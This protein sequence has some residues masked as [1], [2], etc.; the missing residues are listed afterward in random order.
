M[1]PANAE[2]VDAYIESL[3]TAGDAVLDGALAMAHGAGLPE[4]QVSAAQGKL[5]YLLARAMGAS[6][7]LEIGTL[8]GYSGIWL[9][10]ALP[11]TGTLVTLEKDS[12]H[13]AV[14]RAN[15]EGAGL[16]RRI[17]LLEGDAHEILASLSGPPFDMVFIDAEK[18]G[19]TRYLQAVLPLTRPGSL[20][21]ADNVVRAGKVLAPGDDNARG[22]A[23]FNE[24]LAATEGVEATIVQTVG[25][26]GHDGLAFA[27]VR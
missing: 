20:I 14:A 10:R 21:V 12:R 4:I 3:F 22:A 11:E 15:F 26:K 24:A 27:V 5:L 19:Y 13:A 6:R 1:T 8:G 16:S 7:I 18:P 25:V 17:T 2:A 9:A 23:A